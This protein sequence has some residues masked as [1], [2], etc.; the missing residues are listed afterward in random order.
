MFQCEGY[1][2][3][4]DPFILAGSCGATY[5]LIQ[6]NYAYLDEEGGFDKRYKRIQNHHQVIYDDDRSQ[7]TWPNLLLMAFVGFIFYNVF[8]PSGLSGGS[9]GGQYTASPSSY[10]NWGGSRG[11]GFSPFGGGAGGFFS[12]LGLGT[13][14]GSMWGQSRRYIS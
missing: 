1:E 3:P 6:S 8:C 12:G 4:D 7:L 13:M 9:S 2:H 14:M 10:G 5:E 11:W